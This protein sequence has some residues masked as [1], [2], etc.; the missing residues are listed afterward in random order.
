MRE[1]G[2]VKRRD[3]LERQAQIMSIGLKLFSEKGYNGTSIDD[4]ITTAGI[5]KRTFYLHFESKNDLLNSIIG[6]YFKIIYDAVKVLDL[7]QQIPP[8]EIKKF[9]ID[10][11]NY[12]AKMPELL[13][14]GKLILRDIIGLGDEQLRRFYEFQNALINVIAEYFRKGQKE[15]KLLMEADAAT[16]AVLIV[17]AA[18]ELLFRWLVLEENIDFEKSINTSMDIF[19][20]AVLKLSGK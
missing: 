10:I 18:K 17:G 13:Q 19:S 11:I 5:A 4:I 2:K 12:L 3:G 9:L 16:V 6:L 1:K 8:E 20:R 7:S 15:G 14:F